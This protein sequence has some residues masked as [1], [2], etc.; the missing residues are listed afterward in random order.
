MSKGLLLIDIQNDYFLGGAMELEGMED[1]ARNCARLLSYFREQELPV[2]HI[3][4]IATREGATFFI[5]NTF[6]CKIH[7]L[8]EPMENEPVIVKN[9]PSSFRET[10]LNELLNSQGADELVIC[11]AMT[12]MCI[13]TTTRAAFDLGYKC[14]VISD[15]C[16]TKSLEFDG[17]QV[18]ASDVQAAYMAALSVPFAQVVSTN[19]LVASL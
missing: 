13:D 5:P 18:L 2:F 8:V 7:E 11:G 1:A 14:T 15:G 16:A 9:Y 12:H 19:A 4:H 10:N 17:K 3:Q 6:G